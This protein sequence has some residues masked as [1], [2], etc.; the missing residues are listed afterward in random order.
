LTLYNYHSE[1]EKEK[2]SKEDKKINGFG[3][4]KLFVSISS[5]L[6]LLF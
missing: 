4:N 2:M 5:K 1:V 6:I 3:G